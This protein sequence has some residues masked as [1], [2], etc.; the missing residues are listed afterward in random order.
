[1]NGSRI[2]SKLPSTILPRTA[3]TKAS[4]ILLTF[5]F[6]GVVLSANPAQTAPEASVYYVAPDGDDSNPG[7]FTAPWRTIG[8]AAGP[9]VLRP[10]DTVYIRGGIYDEYIKPETSGAPGSF[11]TYR[12]YPGETPVITGSSYRYW[13]LHILDQSYLRFQGLTF[14]DYTGGAIQIRTIHKDI[15]GVEIVGNTFRN[16]SPEPGSS[17]KTI[18]VTPY[19]SGYTLYRIVIQD[20][21]FFNMDTYKAPVVQFDGEVVNSMIAGNT[22]S[23]SSNIAIGLAG[24]PSKGQPRNILVKGNDVSGHGSP[25]RHAAGI[26][27]DGVGENVVVEENVVHDGM[28]G[29][30]VDLEPE[31]AALTSRWVIVRRNVLYNNTQI[32]L[33]LGAGETCNRSGSLR[34]SVAV[35]NTVYSDINNIANA[36][37]NCS[38]NMRWKNNIFVHYGPTD[39]LQY[40]LLDENVNTST[41]ILDNNLFLNQSGEGDHYKWLGQRYDTLSRFQSVS[42]QDVSSREGAPLFTDAANFDFTLTAASAARD[43]GGA[44]TVT[45]AA[46]SGTDVP[47]AAAWY[48]S[49]GLGW[50]PGD[51]VQIGNN[52]PVRV[53]AV[54]AS[55]RQITVS[56]PIS[57]SERDPVSYAYADNAP[58]AGAFEFEPALRLAGIPQDRAILL[59]WQVN[60]SLTTDTT[61]RIEYA[62]PAGNQLSPIA[63][64]PADT[65]SFWLTGLTNYTFYDI[66]VSAMQN[67]QP[68]LAQTARVM[69]TD[70]FVFLS[71]IQNRK[72]GMAAYYPAR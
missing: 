23:G 29:I 60:D 55:D 32:N 20:N 19:T 35:H 36:S 59:R 18:T 17:S 40:R 48:F 67:G 9:G 56:R 49:D 22:L 63:P 11:I 15:T 24:R 1:M 58:D 10:G 47:V 71:L 70:K 13:R 39:G 69:P 46:G 62:G 21:Q 54:A 57:W 16:Q 61:W 8:R 41:W 44:L 72:V 53:V 52:G 2:F 6:F 30:K 5:L 3:V 42:S 27:L 12:N 31:A 28:Q 51:M 66:T 45:T 65:R 25:G 34:E 64:L 14:Q 7:T 33:K 37:F 26:Y 43:S 68:V 4:M 38:V 50:Q